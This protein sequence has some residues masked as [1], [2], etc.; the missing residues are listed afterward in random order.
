M[1]WTFI[2]CCYIIR[3]FFS[4][5][6]GI[7][8]ITGQ[9]DM[10]M[11]LK[12]TE[13]EAI[14]QWLSLTFVAHA[15]YIITLSLTL[16]FIEVFGKNMRSVWSSQHTTVSNSD[17]SLYSIFVQA[18]HSPG[19]IITIFL[20][21]SFVTFSSPKMIF[22]FKE[23]R[24]QDA[25]DIQENASKQFLAILKSISRNASINGNVAG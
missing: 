6:L 20:S 5:T 24:F 14:W 12:Y 7:H 15:H 19:L 2:P 4:V 1:G 10:V 18:W 22:Q 11:S 9:F 16:S 13:W 17:D 8:K 25:K 23:T 3:T 21:S